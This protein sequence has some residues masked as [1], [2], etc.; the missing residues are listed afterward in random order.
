MI[1]FLFILFAALLVLGVPV[2]FT[3]ILAAALAMIGYTSFSL[4]VIASRLFEQSNS[5]PLLAI[6][7]FILAGGIMSQGSMSDRLIKLAS[8]GVGQIRG[9]LAM[10]SVL[11]CMFFAA[12]SGSTA[13][14]IAAVGMVMMPALVETGFSRGSATA[15]QATAG[16]VGIIIPPSIPLVLLG[17]ISGISIGG[18]F[19]G[20]VLPGLAI[21]A[22]LM[23]VAHVIAR[24]ED[25]EPS[26]GQAADP[27]TLFDAAKKALLPLLT[28]L[29]VIGGIVG[30]FVTPTEAAIVAVVWALFVSLVVYRDMTLADLP[31]VLVSTANLTG[32]VVFCIGATAPFAWLLTIEQVPA[33]IGEAMLALTTSPVLLKLMMIALLLAIGTFLDLAPAMI[34][35][36]PLLLPISEQIGMDP[37]HF[38]IMLTMALGIGQSTPPVGIALFVA[39]SISKTKME[40]ITGP[41]LPYLAVM[42]AV[43]LAVTFWPD[44]T[45]WLPRVF[46]R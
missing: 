4:E 43:L 3:L 29:F 28:V 34:L 21:G 8:A 45:T 41:V 20:G 30:G 44:L 24:T 22:A 16:S 46:M 1:A 38:G 11:A 31:E 27:T 7:F 33:Q 2:S 17:V 19:L 10:V 9:G 23:G 18:L 32:I 5:F 37:V 13:A 42:I 36:V 14:T 25:H 26:G 39:C 35:L 15:L 12:L 40:D 6:P